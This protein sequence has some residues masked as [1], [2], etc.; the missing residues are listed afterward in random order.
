MDPF[1]RAPF[2]WGREDR[3][4]VDWYR[5]LGRVRAGCACLRDGDFLPIAASG[6]VIA[7]IRSGGVSPLPTARRSESGNPGLSLVGQDG[8][9]PDSG[10]ALL[11]AVNRAPEERTVVVPPEW[12]EAEPLFGALPDACGFLTLPPYGRLCLHARP[13]LR[14]SGNS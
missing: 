10:D 9:A 8:E 3:G 13:A 6:D 11:C 5:L 4:L 1:N 7:Y 12:S 14:N 2:P